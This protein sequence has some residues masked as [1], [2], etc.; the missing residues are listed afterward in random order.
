M[1]FR[2]IISGFAGAGLTFSTY[3]GIIYDVPALFVSAGFFL[4]IIIIIMIQLLSGRKI[5]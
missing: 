3:F 5:K 1:V 2:A 4:A